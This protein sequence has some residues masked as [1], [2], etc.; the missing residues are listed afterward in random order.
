[1]K[2]FMKVCALTTVILIVLGAALACVAGATRSSAAISDVVESVTGGRVHL[3]LGSQWGDSW[4]LWLDNRWY[5]IDM[6]D[7]YD[8]AFEILEGNVD[9]Y[10]IDSEVSSLN[11]ELGGY[12]F[13]TA[14]SPDGLFHLKA[15]GVGKVQCYVKN[16]VL[17]VKAV[18]TNIKLN[19]PSGSIILY[20]PEGQYFE[21][22]DIELGA[23]QMTLD[24][25]N[26]GKIAL[27]VGAGQILVRNL[28][29]ET[30][31][32]SVGVG[33][34]E[35][36]SMNVDVLDVEVGMG[37]ISGTGTINESVDIECAMGNVELKLAGSPQDFNYRLEMAAGNLDLGKDSYSGLAQE[38]R[39]DNGADKNME[40]ECSM[41][42]VSIQFEE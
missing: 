4:G 1:M 41:G 11:I 25:L 5:D 27:D 28:Q 32:T 42:N 31:T 37:E 16:G 13:E 29:A 20:V 35:I 22:V 38:R 6:S 26:A 3:R 36:D 33:Q 9:D 30:I 7:I 18:R 40:I 2:K 10:S 24:D 14:V 8:Y 34:L 23:G 17:N 12:E 21:K 15:E 19:N 39:I